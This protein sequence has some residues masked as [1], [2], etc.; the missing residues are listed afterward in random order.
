M[1]DIANILA[2]AAPVAATEIDL[3][4][5]AA[6][7][8][9]LQSFVVCNTSNAVRTFRFAISIG[10]HA[11]QLKDYLYYE[12]SMP[13]N[14]TQTFDFGNTVGVTLRIGDTVRLYCL[15]SNISV[16]LVGAFS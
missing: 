16:T 1:A 15:K 3:Y 11:T 8:V 5:V 2:Q 12:Y 10:G 9:L 13:G 14:A 4:K 7:N 6:G